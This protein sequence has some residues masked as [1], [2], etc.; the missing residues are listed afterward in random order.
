M[1]RSDAPHCCDNAMTPIVYGMPGSELVEA[2]GRG[3]VQ[4]GGCCVSDDLPMF[5]CDR[6]G[7][8]VG[9][10][11]DVHDEHFADDSWG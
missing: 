1:K 7:R 5:V 4:L 11:G 10:L 3:E 8:T 6:C 2:A 9:R